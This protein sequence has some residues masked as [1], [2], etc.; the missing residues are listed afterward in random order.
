ME[1]QKSPER[2]EYWPSN[3]G[4]RIT[5]MQVVGLTFGIPIGFFFTILACYLVCIFAS[6]L[7][8]HVSMWIILVLG[9]IAFFGCGGPL[10][11][12]HQA[13][14]HACIQSGV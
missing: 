7:S 14:M 2:L 8:S 11:F 4:V 12:S 13:V 5:A 9:C 10:L 6:I 3:K 1:S